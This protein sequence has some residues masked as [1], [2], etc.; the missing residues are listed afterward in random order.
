MTSLSP[1]T[2][3]NRLGI[4]LALLALYLVWGSTYLA[5]PVALETLSPFPLL[6]FRFLVA[7]SLLY[8]V[9]R[10]RGVPHPTRAEWR[11]A[12]I[13][14]I[15]L[16]NFGLGMV[17]YAQQWVA[18][19]LA[20]VI[21]ATMPLW[22]ALF[23]RLF[24]ARTGLGEVF[25]M[26]LGLAGVALL[27]GEQDL[28]AHPGALLVFVGPVAWAFGSAYSRKLTQPKGLMASAVQMLAA[29]VVFVPLALFQGDL[30]PK[31]PSAASLL[32]LVYLIFFGSIVAYSAYLYLLEQRVSPALTTSYAYVNPVVAVL[33]GVGLAGE[34]V[35]SRGYFGMG[36]ILAG[37]VLVVTLRAWQGKRNVAANNSG[38][39]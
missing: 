24:G 6:A 27:N 3:D 38:G 29:G 36:V 11:G 26:L 33:L 15:L 13:T 35:S 39:V 2:S 5:N 23:T 10:L 37:V 17:V 21:V 14:G 4:W 31:T 12:G 20:A 8:G 28:R 9:L 16:L 22:L 30:L 1:S 19:S 34:T 7:G 18:S 25:G 32:A